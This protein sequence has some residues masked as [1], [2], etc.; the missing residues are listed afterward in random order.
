MMVEARVTVIVVTW[1]AAHDIARSLTSIG[2]RHPVVV[3]DNASTDDTLGVVSAVAPGARVIANPVNT[4]FAAGANRGLE[5]VG[6][7]FALLLNPDCRVEP[8]AIDALVEFADRHPRSGLMSAAIIDE[9]GQP[10]AAAG[11]RQPSLLSVAVHELGLGRLLPS[12]SVYGTATTE[13]TRKGWVAGTC[14][15]V[16]REAVSD[17]GPL[18]ESYFLYC[19]D[20]DW[21]RRMEAAGWEV[22]LVPA[23][24]ARHA[25]SSAVNHAGPWVDEY[26]IGSADRYFAAHHGSAALTVFRLLR[27]VGLGGRALALTAIAVVARDAGI[28]RRARQR[29]GDAAR[30]SRLLRG[31]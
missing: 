16:R 11:G 8:G 7:E 24:R 30:A 3:V 2:L 6:T 10:E 27:I 17:V 19:E 23:G 9:L 31:R 4:G 12:W 14:L 22:W 29:R 1:N 25:R 18:D 20:Q 21:C 5:E 13:A 26:R 15:L 28:A